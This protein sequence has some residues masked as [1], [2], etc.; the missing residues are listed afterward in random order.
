MVYEYSAKNSM[1]IHIIYKS[2][3]PGILRTMSILHS[4]DKIRV[5]D[6]FNLKK[7]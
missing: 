5:M 2:K 6:V 3:K 1:D 4:W 7:L